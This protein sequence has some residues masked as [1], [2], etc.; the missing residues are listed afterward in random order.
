VTFEWDDA[1]R[2]HIERHNVD[3]SDCEIALNDPAAKTA[4]PQAGTEKRWRTI[5]H[6]NK[7]RLIVIWTIRGAAIRVVTAWWVGRR[8]R[9]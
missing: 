4:G 3:P 7:R 6:V 5:G 8:T 2:G 1:N 9:V